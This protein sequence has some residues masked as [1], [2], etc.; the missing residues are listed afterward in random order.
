MSNKSPIYPFDL[1]TVWN[2]IYNFQTPGFINVYQ[3]AC[4]FEVVWGTRSSMLDCHVLRGFGIYTIG[5]L[6]SL[7]DVVGG[8]SWLL[9]HVTP[10]VISSII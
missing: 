8:F 1:L 10:R 2:Y 7:S 4:K 5:I 9:L 3:S 6:G